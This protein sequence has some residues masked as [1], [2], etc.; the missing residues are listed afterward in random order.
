MPAYPDNKGMNALKDSGIFFKI[1]LSQLAVMVLQTYIVKTLAM[2]VHK[3]QACAFTLSW[4]SALPMCIC[5]PAAERL[6]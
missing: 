3:Q 2:M 4:E 6:T 5:L 1:S